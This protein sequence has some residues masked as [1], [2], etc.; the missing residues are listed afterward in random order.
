VA[1]G[2]RSPEEGEGDAS[3][4][5]A[6]SAAVQVGEQ[7]PETLAVSVDASTTKPTGTA[8][9]ALSAG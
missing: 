5:E 2:Q 8:T 4:D 1:P 9:C 3:I 7:A 6:T